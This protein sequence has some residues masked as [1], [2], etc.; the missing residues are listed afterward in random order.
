M[1]PSQRVKLRGPINDK[2]NW[3]SKEEA[4]RVLRHMN[5]MARRKR[6]ITRL[7]AVKDECPIATN[8]RRMINAVIRDL[9]NGVL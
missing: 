2:Y 5:E 6:V 3:K 4:D 1:T 9:K 8:A 7:E